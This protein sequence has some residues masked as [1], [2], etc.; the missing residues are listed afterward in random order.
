MILHYLKLASLLGQTVKNLPANAGEPRFDPWFGKIPWR[1]EWQ[2]TSVL[3]ENPM[4]RG[5]CQATARGVTE[6]WTLLTYTFTFTL[7][8]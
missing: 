3:P 5:A 4:D 8:G 7:V 6:S 1:R 2:L